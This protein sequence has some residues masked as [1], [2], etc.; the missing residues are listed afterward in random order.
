MR[1]IL[2]SLLAIFILLAL[3]CLLTFPRGGGMAEVA[4]SNPKY[5]HPN[6]HFQ[7]LVELLATNGEGGPYWHTAY[8]GDYCDIYGKDYEKIERCY[9]AYSSC[10]HYL[11]VET[12]NGKSTPDL[13][14]KNPG[15]EYNE[16]IRLF[17]PTNWRQS[18]WFWI[19]RTFFNG[20][21]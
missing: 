3:F 7:N 15:E 4:Q 8:I 19:G 21:R 16:C 14:A 11:P 17:K 18:I 20:S 6:K 13:F 9:Y 1:S 12:K 5:Q 10:E 2:G